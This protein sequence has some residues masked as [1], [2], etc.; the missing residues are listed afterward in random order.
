MKPVSLVGEVSDFPLRPLALSRACFASDNDS[1]TD[2]EHANGR[3]EKPLTL[4][5]T[6]TTPDRWRVVCRLLA[7][8]ARTSRELARLLER[9]PATVRRHSLV[10][11]CARRQWRKDGHLE[12]LPDGRYRP[13]SREVDA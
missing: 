1:Y 10:D 4:L 7:A 3:N 12:R 13:A 8:P 11:D 6:P 2:P 5:T 9:L